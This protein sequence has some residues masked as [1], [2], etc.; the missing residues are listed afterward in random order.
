MKTLDFVVLFFTE[1]T[2]KNLNFDFQ[3]EKKTT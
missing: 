3:I 2:I 1:Y